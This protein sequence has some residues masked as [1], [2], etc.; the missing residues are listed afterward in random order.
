MK[1]KNWLKK[2]NKAIN[3]YLHFFARVPRTPGKNGIKSELMKLASS[4]LYL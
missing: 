2:I 4:K 1:Y 3:K